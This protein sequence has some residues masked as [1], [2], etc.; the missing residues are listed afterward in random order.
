MPVCQRFRENVKV[1]DLV[2]VIRSGKNAPDRVSPVPMTFGLLRYAFRRDRSDTPQDFA[3]RSPEESS[4]RPCISVIGSTVARC[5]A[6]Q[7]ELTRPRSSASA[8]DTSEFASP[9]SPHSVSGA[10]FCFRRSGGN[11]L[12]AS[13]TLTKVHRRP[14]SN[15]TSASGRFLPATGSVSANPV[16]R[17]IH[18]KRLGR[19]EKRP[20][21]DPALQRNS[22]PTRSPASEGN[23]V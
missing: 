3:G 16:R 21:R 12:R 7:D 13:R 1:T 2:D 18:S 4:A 19:S 10:I 22:R 15:S 23:A 5:S 9:T 8:T 11:K 20:R 6:R 14:A 17:L